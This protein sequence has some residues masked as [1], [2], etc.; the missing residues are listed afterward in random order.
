ML[1]YA[2][3]NVSYP[4]E[5]ITVFKRYLSIIVLATLF[6]L[7]GAAPAQAYTGVASYYDLSGNYTASG[8]VLEYD[9]LTCASVAYPFGTYL[10]ITWHGA[11]VTCVVTDTGGFA[12]LGRD[13][14]MN[15]GVAN[16]LGFAQSG[17]GV[18]YVDI[19]YAGYDPWWHWYKQY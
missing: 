2:P 14:D 8:D 10:T 18:D 3:L 7:L 6:A 17:V 4:L 15:I 13:V 19:Q 1:Y 11:S 12:Y 9:D 5:G 16:A